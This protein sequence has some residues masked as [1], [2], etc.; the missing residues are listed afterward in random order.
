MKHKYQ[1]LLNP[2]FYEQFMDYV[3]EHEYQHYINGPFDY[4]ED[5][6]Y[7]KHIERKPYR[8]Q[9]QSLNAIYPSICEQYREVLDRFI[10]ERN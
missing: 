9:E 5:L 7:R 4:A 1:E 10:E 3:L 8:V 2:E 6:F